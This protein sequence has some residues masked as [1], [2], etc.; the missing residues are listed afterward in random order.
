MKLAGD[1]KFVLNIPE[2]VYQAMKLPE[3]E[4]RRKD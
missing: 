2:D 3:S 1:K 4:E